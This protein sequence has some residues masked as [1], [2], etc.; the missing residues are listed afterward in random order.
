MGLIQILGDRQGRYIGQGVA[1]DG[2]GFQGELKLEP[3]A[4][5]NGL[6]L[7]YT[8]SREATLLHHEHTYLA[9]DPSGLLHLWVVSNNTPGLVSHALVSEE[10]NSMGEHVLA[11]EHG[12]LLGSEGFRERILVTLHQGGALS[13]TYSWGMPGE[14]VAERSHVKLYPSRVA[15]SH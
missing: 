7:E 11:F 14:P 15:E 8:A 12:D 10:Y 3:L 6:R 13:Y 9:P 5:C 2:D 1:H 4:H